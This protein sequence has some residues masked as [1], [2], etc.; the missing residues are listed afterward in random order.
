MT[1][2]EKSAD[3]TEYWKHQIEAWQVSAQSQKAFCKAH[4][5]NYHQFGY[6]SRKFRNPVD[7]TERK[8]PSGFVPVTVNAPN[9]SNGL[10]LRLPN[11]MQLQGISNDNLPTVYQLLAHL[12]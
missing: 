6:W 2:K 11:G 9:E 3:L 8:R 10:L 1:I 7:Q 5:L 4:D 12:S